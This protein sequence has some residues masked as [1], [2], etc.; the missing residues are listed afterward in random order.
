M[1]IPEDKRYFVYKAVFS[2]GERF[3]VVLHTDT[4]QPA[5]LATRY[6]LDERR[7]T[8][9]A[10][11]IERDARVL[12]WLY[13]WSAF[14][15]IN[16]EGQLRSGGSLPARQIQGFSRWLRSGRQSKLVGTIGKVGK[17]AESKALA[18]Q[19]GTFNSY[20]ATVESFLIWAVYEFV[21]KIEST[22]KVRKSLRD[23]KKRIRRAFKAYRA[24]ESIERAK[25][26]GLTPEEIDELR[27]LTKPGEDQNP[28]RKQNQF[29]NNLIVETM[30][31]T[32]VRAGE[33]LKIRIQDLP[34]GPK[35]TLSIVRRPDD[36]KDPRKDEP[37]VKTRSREIPIPRKLATDLMSYVQKVRGD[38]GHHF[39][40]ISSRG[41]VPLSKAGLSNVFSV[42]QK[43]YQAGGRRIHP[44]LLRHTFNDLLMDRAKQIG[45][46]DDVRVKVQNFL[47]G[48]AEGSSQSEVY[49][50][51]FVEA[52]ALQL[53]G[54]YQERLW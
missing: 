4:L 12:C 14:A 43:K 33:L 45:M 27:T 28:F 34:R 23:A 21:P 6:I 1:I 10:S 37:R 18:L 7:E 30:L 47:C 48:W 26:Y 11:T 38:C 39:L 24:V 5:I 50:R 13:E 44:H 54:K 8:R 19:P 22:N 2:T 25:R 42:L 29:R 51:R 36:S 41:G 52:E 53:I 31:A 9:Q 16:L 40:F 15:G 32:G 20:L 35:Q 3:P 46:P 17:G 49:T